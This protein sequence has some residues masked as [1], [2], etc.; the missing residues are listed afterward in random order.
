MR[1]VGTLLG[2]FGKGLLQERRTHPQSLSPTDGP[3]S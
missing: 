2:P 1:G 3:P